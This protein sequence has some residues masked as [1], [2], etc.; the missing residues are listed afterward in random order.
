[1]VENFRKYLH[2]SLLRLK[3][4]R[5]FSTYS[6]ANEYFSKYHTRVLVNMDAI[7]FNV[8]GDSITPIMRKE[9]VLMNDIGQ[10]WIS[11]KLCVWIVVGIYYYLLMN[12]YSMNTL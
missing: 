9:N 10:S 3:L 6:G 4:L 8:S 11:L 1:M 7:H 2:S 5:F 12:R